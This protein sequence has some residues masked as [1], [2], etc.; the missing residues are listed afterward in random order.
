[1]WANPN[2]ETVEHN[3][4]T[5]SFFGIC[6]CRRES[7]REATPVERREPVFTDYPASYQVAPANNNFELIIAK[8]LWIFIITLFIYA[9]VSKIVVAGFGL[10]HVDT[11]DLDE[12]E[13]FHVEV[14]IDCLRG[15][16]YGLCLLDE[17]CVFFMIIGAAAS[18]RLLASAFDLLARPKA[19]TRLLDRTGTGRAWTASP[20]VLFRPGQNVDAL[21]TATSIATFRRPPP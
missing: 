1:M 4:V 5:G 12:E 16:P 21:G 15:G 2:A 19:V 18:S 11:E 20:S 17:T 8:V 6:T 10:G 9:T 13:D 3:V 14:E 7:L